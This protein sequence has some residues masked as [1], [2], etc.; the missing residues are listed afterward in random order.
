MTTLVTGASGFVGRALCSELTQ[1]GKT[2][3]AATRGAANVGTSTDCVAVGSVDAATD[4]SA[5]L[6]GVDA[7]AH[8]A[9][10]VHVMNDRASDPLTLFRSVNTDGALNLARQAA[11]AGVRRVVFV[12]SVKVAGEYSLASRPFRET[13]PPQPQDAYAVSKHEAEIGLRQ[14]AAETGLEITIVRPPLVYGPGVR[15]NF[16]SLM[17]AVQRGWPLPFAAIDN[18]RSLVGIDNLVDFIALCLVHPGAANQTFFVSDGRDLSTP[19]LARELSAALQVPARLV[20]VPIWALRAAGTVTGKREA[21]ARLCG[22]LQ[23]DISCARQ[24]LGW[25][26]PLDVTTGLRRAAAGLNYRGSRHS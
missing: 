6:R 25:L 7:V 16:Q 10:R 9:A 2:V 3:R 14:L 4:W 22:N 1:R 21:V 19:A 15:A 20:P 24:L 5:A 8:L 13:D 11:A 23:V 17:N 12:S 18:R 26:P